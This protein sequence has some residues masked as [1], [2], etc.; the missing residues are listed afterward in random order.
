MLRI[1]LSEGK[2]A[3]RKAAQALGVLLTRMLMFRTRARHKRA[4]R[5]LRTRQPSTVLLR[6]KLLRRLAEIEVQQYVILCF[7]SPFHI[8]GSP[9]CSLS[10]HSRDVSC[11]RLANAF[12][13]ASCPRKQ[14]WRVTRTSMSASRWLSVLWSPETASTKPGSSLRTTRLLPASRASL[15]YQAKQ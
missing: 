2:K 3:L 5:S 7:S 1:Q 14:G 11:A 15:E 12:A 10:V 6:L 4:V 9:Q 8:R 13:P